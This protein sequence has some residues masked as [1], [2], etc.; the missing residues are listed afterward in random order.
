M[1]NFTGQTKKRVVNLGNKQSSAVNFLEQTRLQRQ[2]REEQ[3]QRERAANILQGYVKWYL[4]LSRIAETIDLHQESNDVVDEYS[5]SRYLASFLFVCR[6]KRSLPRE[7]IISNITDLATVLKVHDDLLKT[8]NKFQ[9]ER[10]ANNIMLVFHKT[11]N[12]TVITEEALKILLII[13]QQEVANECL[14]PNVILGLQRLI[15]TTLSQEKLDTI[16]NIIFAINVRDSPQAFIS[17]LCGRN[18]HLRT[19]DFRKSILYSTIP[20][21]ISI[22]QSLEPAQ[23]VQLLLNILTLTPITSRKQIGP[24]D[25]IIIGTVL[26]T[27]SFAL[28]DRVRDED[29]SDST[30][31]HNI[32][33]VDNES[34]KE[35][36][37]LYSSAFIENAIE[38][39]TN[40]Q[41]ELSKF[42][43][44][45]FS[46]LLFLIPPEKKKL[47][48]MITITPG[49]YKWFFN[50]LCHHELY[51]NFKTILARKDYLDSQDLNSVLQALSPASVA[52]FWKMLYTFE[53]LYSY[54][55]I[56][57]NDTES[58]SDDKLNLESIVDFME[59]LKGLCLTFI[60]SN[61]P[62]CDNF[63]KI[64]SI[65]I[66]LL[67]Q[68][69][70]KNTRLQFLDSRFW[71][72]KNFNDN[73]DSLIEIIA[74]GH[75]RLTMNDDMSDEEGSQPIFGSRTKITNDSQARLEVLAKMPFI[76]PFKSRVRVFQRLIELDRE[77]NAPVSY[78][79]PRTT[80]KADIRRE[81][82]LEDAFNNFNNIGQ[83]FK[84]PL[85][86]TF[87]NEYGQ[88]AGIDGGGIT[89]EF[90]T[91]VV[92]EGFL[93][94]G[95]FD[96]FKETATNNQLYPND[97]I[98]KKL[99]MNYNVPEQKLKLEYLRFLGAIVGKCL[100]ENVLIDVSFAPFFINKWSN[101][102]HLMKS[103][104]NDLRSLDEELFSNL[105]KLNSMS[106]QELVELDLNFMIEEQV[107][108]KKFIYDLMPPN[109][110]N[111]QVNHNNRLNYIHQVSN[112]K[113]NQSLHLQTK[114]F[115]EGLFE[116]ISAA[117]LTMFDP[118][119]LQ[120][121][122][123]GGEQDINIDDW[124]DNVEY[125][126][127]FDDD[128]TIVY[129]WEVVKEMS[130]QERFKLVKFVT[131][132]SR[133]PLLG[134]QSLTPK[135]GIRNSGREIDRLPTASTC[136]N[137]LKLPDY[138]DKELIRS[139][140]LYAINMGAGFD[141]S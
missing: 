141:L 108:G 133:A 7:R 15:P 81:F 131:S 25:Y 125:G 63:D 140:L 39:F 93:P 123:S 10:I 117:W 136:V 98:F 83:N 127:Y 109:G 58:F 37:L 26:S 64:K 79:G 111:T 80:L 12:D 72:T 21:N 103:S 86:V 76:I 8:L 18:L 77:R 75:E 35:I 57:S 90:L 50:Q 92:Q 16:T 97:E 126:G 55:L 65:S 6:W 14:F 24:S 13:L 9:V 2:A 51:V 20:N 104:I 42:V 60:F 116:M 68:L 41:N 105:L 53:E 69:Y 45:I 106:D 130:P 121:L 19:S 1:L 95:Q 113:L 118:I 44:Y 62:I 82:I 139:K 56:V 11:G 33:G 99:R 91:S 135:F 120:M 132:V 27:I 36:K 67:N 23:K 88:E 110:R 129:F 38:F 49:S 101:V 22:I 34:I 112:F 96:L 3:R 78:F 52:D 61:G 46:S 5:F 31:E 137:L 89:K 94:G 114:Y 48:M 73:I 30:Q 87:F 84:N 71:E 29:D 107:S 119:E 66:S 70:S 4:Y 47:C 128:L 28:S 115:V 32:I 54:W 100:Y 122:I 124:K 85:S 40:S 17:F 134:F 138:Q 43:L 59:F 74:E 102:A